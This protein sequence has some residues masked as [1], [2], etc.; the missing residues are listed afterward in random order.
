VSA[1][2]VYSVAQI[3]ELATGIPPTAAQVT[4]WEAYENSGGSVQSMV[5]AFVASTMFAN[6]YNVGAPVNP[7]ATAGF[8]LTSAIMQSALGVA[9]T[10]PQ[11][12]A[13]LGTGLSTADLFQAFALGDQYGTTLSS[14]MF[15]SQSLDGTYQIIPH[16]PGPTQIMG[17]SDFSLLS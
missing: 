16:D 6:K 12:N 3:I 14:Q 11:V 8:T 9:P 10:E 13:W 15:I 2:G 1:A 5:D 7:D 4:G 17:I